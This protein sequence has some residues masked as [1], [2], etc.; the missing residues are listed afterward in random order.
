MYNIVPV[1]YIRVYIKDN[2]SLYLIHLYL[3]PD[4]IPCNHL[5]YKYKTKDIDLKTEDLE[6]LRLML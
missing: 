6:I 1:K 5:F 3:Y 4:P 2:I